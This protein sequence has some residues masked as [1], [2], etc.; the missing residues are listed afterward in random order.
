MQ[1]IRE[2]GKKERGF[3]A[4]AGLRFAADHM[5]FELHPARAEARVCLDDAHGDLAADFER[6]AGPEV[7]PALADFE[8]GWVA[9][10]GVSAVVEVE[11]QSGLA[12][13]G[14]R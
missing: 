2:W 7:H 10:L 4:V 1:L 14:G 6:P 5:A 3:V 8:V 12:G 9:L 11:R 13:H